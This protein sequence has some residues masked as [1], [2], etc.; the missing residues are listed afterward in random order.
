VIPWL[1]LAAK[2]P[3]S[4]V[5]LILS[6]I[7][8]VSYLA[9]LFN[10]IKHMQGNMVTRKDLVIALATFRE[11]LQIDLNDTYVRRHECEL[12]MGNLGR[13]KPKQ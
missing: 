6:T 3:G 4:A 1:E 13:D 8:F 2:N 12:A 10:N 11:G 5:T 7:A 9:V